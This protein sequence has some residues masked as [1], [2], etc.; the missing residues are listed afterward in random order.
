MADVYVVT[1][2]E[3]TVKK[4]IKETNLSFIV[5]SGINSKGKLTQPKERTFVK[6]HG[7]FITIIATKDLQ[8]AKD[9]AVDT[10]DKIMHKF[11]N[12]ANKLNADLKESMSINNKER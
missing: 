2:T 12:I 4:L 7:H 6:F 10:R 5:E 3:I 1:G 11:D 8:V 9:H